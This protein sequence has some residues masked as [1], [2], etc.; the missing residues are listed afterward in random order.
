MTALPPSENSNS[1]FP[2]RPLEILE[3]GTRP[4]GMGRLD[5]MEEVIRQWWQK[6]HGNKI[7]W[8]RVACYH[9]GESKE[10]DTYPASAYARHFGAYDLLLCYR[11]RQNGQVAIVG[12]SRIKTLSTRRS[13]LKSSAQDTPLPRMVIS[14]RSCF[15]AD[16]FA[17]RSRVLEPWVQCNKTTAPTQE[18]YLWGSIESGLER[19]EQDA[20]VA[21][22][23]DQQHSVD[24]VQLRD[25]CLVVHEM[26]QLIETDLLRL[27]T[28]PLDSHLSDKLHSR[29]LGMLDFGTSKGRLMDARVRLALF[30]YQQLQKDPEPAQLC[31]AKLLQL[32]V[33]IGWP[34]QQSLTWLLRKQPFC[35]NYDAI[36][37]QHKEDWRL[38]VPGIGS[39]TTDS[40]RKQPSK[41]VALESTRPPTIL[42]NES[43]RVC[44]QWVQDES[45]NALRHTPWRGLLPC[46]GTG[47]RTPLL[48]EARLMRL[49]CQ[50]DSRVLTADTDHY[51][52][53]NPEVEADETPPFQ[54]VLQE[55]PTRA[56]LL[57]TSDCD[58]TRLLMQAEQ[59]LRQQCGSYAPDVTVDMVEQRVRHQEH[60]PLA[61]QRGKAD[62]TLVMVV[63]P[64]VVFRSL[65]E[66]QDEWIKKLKKLAQQEALP[67]GWYGM[68]REHEDTA[69]LRLP[70]A[71]RCLQPCAAQL[72][73][74]WQ[75]ISTE[76]QEVQQQSSTE[77]PYC[78]AHYQ[79]A[80]EDT[81]KRYQTTWPNTERPD[82][83]L[84][85]PDHQF[86]QRMAQERRLAHL[87]GRD[88][89]YYLLTYRDV[90]FWLGQRF[91]TACQQSYQG[92]LTLDQLL[93]SD[94][95]LEERAGCEK[96]FEWFT[97]GEK[98]PRPPVVATMP[99]PPPAAAPA[100]TIR[101][102]IKPL[103]PASTG[104]FRLPG[105][106]GERNVW[107][108]YADA[109]GKQL[110]ESFRA[111][112]DRSM[113]IT[114]R[115][116]DP[117]KTHAEAR[118]SFFWHEYQGELSGAGSVD[119]ALYSLFRYK[120]KGSLATLL[121]P[122]EKQPAPDGFQK[123]SATRLLP[124]WQWVAMSQVSWQEIWDYLKQFYERSTSGQLIP[125][126][127]QSGTFKRPA[128]GS[129]Q[130]GNS[131]LTP[132]DVEKDYQN[133]T[134]SLSTDDD[135]CP[136]RLV[137][138]YVREQRGLYM[139]P[140]ALLERSP[141]VRFCA[142]MTMPTVNPS[143]NKK[144][145]TETVSV[146]KKQV[147]PCVAY[148]CVGDNEREHPTVAY[149]LAWLDAKEARRIGERRTYGKQKELN[150]FF[151]V[152][153]GRLESLPVVYL[154]EG[155]EKAMALACC[156]R[157]MCVYAAL[158][159]GNYYRFKRHL[160]TRWQDSPSKQSV[161]LL[162]LCLDLEMPG[163][164]TKEA[165]EK[166]LSTRRDAE[167]QKRQ[168]EQ[169]GWTVVLY[170]P[171]P[172]WHC[173]D[174]DDVVKHQGLYELRQLLEL[175][176]S[177][178]LNEIPALS[179]PQ[180]NGP[181]GTSEWT[182]YCTQ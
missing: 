154:A 79:R 9:V 98:A 81:L 26:L 144:A 148:F 88:T 36:P 63:W 120:H 136:S 2:E 96:M 31:G 112:P 11:R 134:V 160:R 58:L 4:E 108:N 151:W 21:L 128:N 8:S 76:E 102:D 109:H 77:K 75:W 29:Y 171:R 114:Q 72:R 127:A 80:L 118:M 30:E 55:L 110:Y 121:K 54:V 6:N 15:E 138:R 34:H 162:A 117:A 82:W 113:R 180:P 46:E 99:A 116:T 57:C 119:L 150:A 101:E 125:S 178:C 94:M 176:A 53:W 152:Q 147:Q 170:E 172:E 131:T 174:W 175:P 137:H 23:L 90:G 69:V 83:V 47:E 74:E 130:T 52:L 27:K 97:Y 10:L 173:K 56:Y 104:G 123:G 12:A 146:A 86:C 111:D 122:M 145:K 84:L 139:L 115:M 73:R 100:T 1:G 103:V 67:P 20:K 19:Y 60:H 85:E 51:M 92:P 166:R 62:E 43:S 71:A 95:S 149:Q 140:E 182:R 50:N 65:Q 91:L 169:T 32:L 13:I 7:P 124:A 39:I 16:A 40:I 132:E 163:V 44:I 143:G 142:G 133:K 24:P 3:L 158:G 106:D 68:G 156:S 155:P 14:V 37:I 42:L 164:E 64:D 35:Q 179:D 107:R 49:A 93:P 78:D 126:M 66:M 105:T 181:H 159:K 89:G 167:A 45:H 129:I 153:P 33:E 41:R 38:A 165:Q 168:L 87:A 70:P 141:Y 5:H 28:L 177:M 135:A 161:P 17:E 48:W 61:P 59:L 18:Q 22:E 157:Y 25:L